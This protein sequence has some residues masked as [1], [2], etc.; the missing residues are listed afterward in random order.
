MIDS[1][2]LFSIV[3]FGLLILTAFYIVLWH[4]LHFILCKKY[5][6]ILFREP[7]FNRMELAIYNSWPLSLVRSM[8]YVL[9]LA[10]PNFYSAKRRF[11]GVTIDRSNI[12]LL[13]LFCRIFLIVLAL[14]VLFILFII[15]WNIQTYIFYN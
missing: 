15:L 6:D 10:A 5:D 13:T 14:I 11:K 12:F 8:G 1:G 3:F 7:I 2:T 4:I 9:L